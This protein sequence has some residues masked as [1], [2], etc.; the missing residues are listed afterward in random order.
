[1]FGLPESSPLGTPTNLGEFFEPRCL[2]DLAATEEILNQSVRS[3]LALPR[4]VSTR[5]VSA[6]GKRIRPLLMSLVFRSLRR[7]FPEI[8]LRA[9][10]TA[11]PLL[12]AVAEWV[13]TATL[14]HDDVLDASPTRRNLPAAHLIE[15]N[16]VAVLVGDFVYAEAFA[17]LMDQGLLEPSQK[18]AHTVKSLVEGELMQHMAVN[19][20]SLDRLSFEKITQ[21]KTGA[22]FAWCTGTG[23]WLAGMDNLEKTF[24][25]GTKLGIAFQIADDL[26]DT[27]DIDPTTGSQAV[28]QQW[29]ESAPPLPL[30]VASEVLDAPELKRLHDLWRDLRSTEST[31]LNKIREDVH[32]ILH[33]LR[34]PQ[35]L[36][37][38]EQEFTSRMGEAEAILREFRI[39]PD[40]KW[41]TEAIKKRAS[42]GLLLGGSALGP[43]RPRVTSPEIAQFSKDSSIAQ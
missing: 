22:L 1:M 40:L 4:E 21:A 42:A 3:Q 17:L 27:Y 37:K 10:E 32:G 41:A 15:G 33:L 5:L 19:S 18:L 36:Q 2:S 6:G 25:L 29:V 7:A 24:E 28:L 26:L 13:H 20:R 38:C 30:I 14:F 11:L 39:E 8:S 43:E 35:V 12:G 16:K 23:A 9:P 31:S 34:L